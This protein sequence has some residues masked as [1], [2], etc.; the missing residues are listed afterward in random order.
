M[1]VIP[2]IL[3]RPRRPVSPSMMP[4]VEDSKSR[5]G[6]KDAGKNQSP[7]EPE[8]ETPVDEHGGELRFSA[9]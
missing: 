7:P 4:A 2:P 8:T 6:K 9:C 5:P 3:P 1:Y